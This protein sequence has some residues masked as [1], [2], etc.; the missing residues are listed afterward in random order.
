MCGKIDALKDQI[1]LRFT[2]LDRAIAATKV[3][4]DIRLEAMN[5]FRAQLDR[6]S[7]TFVPRTEIDLAHSKLEQKIDVLL[8]RSSERIGSTKWIDHIITVLIGLA[9]I[10][11][12]WMIKK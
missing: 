12:V 3:D 5:E 11:V 2:A 7:N 4:L 9:V 10:L 1:Q 8:T 6:Q